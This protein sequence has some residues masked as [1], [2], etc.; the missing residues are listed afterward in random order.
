MLQVY[1]IL[2]L[3]LGKIRES[4]FA[5]EKLNH[6]NNII[7][8]KLLVK[9]DDPS[10][11]GDIKDF[12]EYYIQSCEERLSGYYELDRAK[13]MQKIDLL[14]L[15]EQLRVLE[16]FSRKLKLYGV[17]LEHEW[18]RS[19]V[20]IK[21]IQL[22][23]RE[24][25]LKSLPKL[26]F[27]LATYNTVSLVLSIFILFLSYSV[28]LL[29]APFDIMVL[30]NSKFN[31]ISTNSFINHIMNS[32]LSFCDIDSEFEINPINPMGVLVIVTSKAILLVLILGYLTEELKRKLIA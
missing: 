7:Q 31:N 23:K 13:I 18:V 15:S 2:E 12:L 20:K 19:E 5:Y 27:Y 1:Q 6:I 25:K 4:K 32:L 29:P 26:L 16:F 22:C 28:I 17:D 21:Y 8:L 3:E 30:F 11:Y 24:P 9:S 10:I 14:G